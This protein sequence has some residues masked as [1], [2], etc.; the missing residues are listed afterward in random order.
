MDIKGLT[1]IV[2][3]ASGRLGSAIA[4]GLAARG[5]VCLCHYHRNGQT[6]AAL[7]ER[8]A[9]GGGC[10]LAVQADLSNPTDIETL[11]ETAK[12]L[13]TP[14]IL[15]NSASLF[16]RKP[17]MELDAVA[18]QRTLAVNLTAPMLMCRYFTQAVKTA[19]LTDSQTGLPVAKI[20]NLT[21]AAAK[22]PW[23]E[24]AAYCASKAGLVGLTVA[25]AKELAPAITVNAIAPGIVTATEPMSQ[26]EEKKQLARIPAGRFGRPEEIVRSI[27]FLLDNDYITGQTLAVDGGRTI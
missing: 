7:V 19:G 24:Y 1:A 25:L 20:I 13:G 16:E 10:A 26:H 21:D 12:T 3:G 11:F 5:V 18:I 22:K 2:T 15:I 9:S 27:L 23:A 17:L 4:A 6:A 14:R 8:I